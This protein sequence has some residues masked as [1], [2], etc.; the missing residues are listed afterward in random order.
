VLG[1]GF[2]KKDYA[3][4]LV[5]RW[6]NTEFDGGRHQRRLRKIQRIEESKNV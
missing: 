4:R 1:A 2:I 3:V 5:A 6:L